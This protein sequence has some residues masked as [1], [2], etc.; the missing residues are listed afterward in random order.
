MG[1]IV[2]YAPLTCWVENQRVYDLI[3]NTFDVVDEID[4]DLTFEEKYRKISE[5]YHPHLVKKTDQRVTSNDKIKVF[6]IKLTN[7]NVEIMSRREHKN[8]P[9]YVDLVAFKRRAR[10]LRE[11]TQGAASVLHT[12]DWLNE[13]NHFF[14]VFGMKKWNM[15]KY[16]KIEDLMGVIW[17]EPGGYPWSPRVLK[18]VNETPHY[19]YITGDKKYYESYSTYEDFGRSL[20]TFDKMI[21]T[22]PN[23]DLQKIPNVL[24]LKHPKLNVDIIWNGLH[25]CSIFRANNIEY[26]RGIYCSHRKGKNMFSENYYIH[27][28]FFDFEKTMMQLNDNNIRYT[29][30]RGYKKLPI[31][32]DSD[33]DIVCHPDDLVK[34]KSIFD[35][36]LN[37]KNELFFEINSKKCTYLQYT[38]DRIPN[39]KISNTHFHLDVYDGCFTTGKYKLSFD[40]NFLNMLFSNRIKKDSYYIA[41]TSYEYFL[42]LV[43]MLLDCS[44]IKRK[45]IDYLK[46]LG[47]VD[48]TIILQLCEYITDTNVRNYFIESIKK[49]KFI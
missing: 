22:I 3:K 19:H 20:D 26:I 7:P 18:K 31:T 34:L 40:Y 17:L 39:K 36:N 38:T 12:P 49:H 5:L 11:N 21:E 37:K 29:I 43:R 32:P 45:H 46:E 2:E 15:T 33:L 47:N 44:R 6:I 42:L 9:M 10:L 4:L 14:K 48:D 25:R 28:H 13:S 16:F 35:K 23:T 41:D 27:D 8:K 24:I 1:D 30:I